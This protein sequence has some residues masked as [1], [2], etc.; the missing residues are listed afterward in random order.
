MRKLIALA[1]V[2]MM[3]VAC[4]TSSNNT[5]TS[6]LD[7]ANKIETLQITS[8]NI[9]S[10]KNIDKPREL[11]NLEI[12][13]IMDY[14]ANKFVNSKTDE[15]IITCKGKTILERGDYPLDF[16]LLLEDKYEYIVVES[17]GKRKWIF[18][19]KLD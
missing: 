19:W 3:L 11:N 17:Q 5:I 1:I 12:H 4:D 13:E 16:Y 10:P 18:K 6:C 14:D 15:R 7:L 2:L 8:K 9:I